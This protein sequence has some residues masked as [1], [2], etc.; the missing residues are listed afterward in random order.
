MVA[1]Q[2]LTG[3]IRKLNPF[4]PSSPSQFRAQDIEA[5]QS[6]PFL[7]AVD[8][9]TPTCEAS[10]EYIADEKPEPIAVSPAFVDRVWKFLFLLIP[11][12]PSF[13]HPFFSGT[14]NQATR[15]HP[16]SWVDGFRGFA[17]F[18]VFI[19]HFAEPFHNRLPYGFG[20]PGFEDDGTLSATAE[21]LVNL[22]IMKLPIIRLVYS[23]QAMVS[24][25][26]V[27]S[28]FALSY[29][30]ISLLRERAW[31]RLFVSLSSAAFRRSIRLLSPMVISTAIPVVL[32]RLG[33][34]ELF[35]PYNA[36]L[37]Y[38]FPT[39]IEQFWSWLTMTGKGM[40]FLN[41]SY[42]FDWNNYGP[43]TW[44]ILV[45]LKG[46]F[47]L[48]LLVLALCRLKVYVRF[49][50]LAAMCYHCVRTGLWEIFC[51]ISG[52]ILAELNQIRQETADDQLLGARFKSNKSPILSAVKWSGIFIMALYLLSSP[53]KRADV[54]P[55]YM[56]LSVLN[57]LV[58]HDF[59]FWHIMGSILL[60]WSV[61]CSKPLQAIFTN[62]FAQYLGKISFSLYLVHFFVVET[63]GYFLVK[64]FWGLIGDNNAFKYEL[65][66]C[67]SFVILLPIVIWIADMFWRAVDMRSLTL[68]KWLETKWCNV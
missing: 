9:W 47:V 40:D 8:A 4:A 53:D 19:Y 12:L 58:R 6:R 24:A 59:R 31:D 14:P 3:Y 55:G 32:L 17:S 62:G 44:T 35:R 46:S 36:G 5:T 26:F 15:I 29:K 39:F 10:F 18:F 2:V 67:L 11:L 22:S 13:V 25:F 51:F 60:I 21:G 49:L 56:L 57:P 30:P 27:I 34:Y 50:I 43:Q 64:T 54:T 68:S 33:I 61:G 20:A 48:F 23:G 45:E 66:W 7:S 52:I 41:P 1:F 65:G 38:R 42:A 16:T 37:P 28:G 63:M